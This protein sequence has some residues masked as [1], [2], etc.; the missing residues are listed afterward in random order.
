MNA[1]MQVNGTAPSPSQRYAR[2]T[3]RTNPAKFS[4]RSFDAATNTFEAVIATEYPYQRY[5]DA[6]EILRCSPQ[7][8]SLGDIA[9]KP[10]LD[11]HN[12]GSTNGL[13][14]CI[15]AAW[16]EG[17]SIV[18]KIR[19]SGSPEGRA[20]AAKVKEGV[21]CKVSVGY[22]VKKVTES[23]R[24]DGLFNMSV[25]R[26]V[27]LEVSLVSV[28]ADPNAKIRSQESIDMDP[29]DDIETIE[30][31]SPADE[32]RS[33]TQTSQRV[34]RQIAQIR[35][36]AIGAGI[37]EVDADEMLDGIRTVNGARAAVFDVLAERSRGLRTE[38]GRQSRGNH[39]GGE[40][41]EAR[42]AVVEELA[43]RLGAKPAG[44][45]RPYA[46]LRTVEIGRQWF[47]TNGVST[48][49]FDDSRIADMMISPSRY[50]VRGHT[51]SDFPLILGEAS[52]RAL[53]AR[54]ADQPPALKALSQKRSARD[55]RPQSFI[56]PGE[57]PR[58]EKVSEK[59][60]VKHG[61]LAEEK[62]GLRIE[63]YAKIFGLSRQAIVNDDLGAFAD[64]IR[65]FSESASQTEGDLFFELLSANGLSGVVLSDGVNLFH[66]DHGNKAAAGGA[67][68]VTTLG[69][70]RE[71]MRLQKN[72]N[73][74]GGAGVKPAVLL[75][76]PK[77]E[78]AAEKLV[79]E[80]S[81]AT[82]GEVNPF[83]GKLRVEVENRYSGNGWWL[84]G[85]P[86]SRP[87]LM[88]GYLDGNEGPQ[89]ETREGWEV[90]GTEFRCVLDFGCGILDWRAAYFNPGAA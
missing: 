82:V 1:S 65:S 77:L 10:V 66:A 8:V 73:G 25:D 11:S 16:F 71:A 22:R 32:A 28:P 38:P 19:L 59:G 7:A 43:A 64:F 35:D 54:Y 75:V 37:A 79:A 5:P 51:V 85:D 4:P 39:G 40:E 3:E 60:E 29:E 33:R 9:G 80:I 42:S 46:A 62:N 6:F 17:N 34:R 36:Q 52:N 88:H 31:L 45:N 70:G 87:A 23:K 18:A 50:A 61:T 30:D 83:G 55:F 20:V 68:S 90:L 48:R 41:H 53:L 27:I 78:T 56:R 26:W 72:V 47:E 57:A 15:D 86:T 49:S 89:V 84:F 44:G 67:L 76:G 69:A 74:T 81:A 58:L 2:K 24:S 14:G 12:R 21:L 13:I 63:T